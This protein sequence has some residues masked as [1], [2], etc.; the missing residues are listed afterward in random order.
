MKKKRILKRKNYYLPPELI[1]R[2]EKY[3]KKLKT[4]GSI[5]VAQLLDGLPE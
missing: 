2:G 3:A 5:V 1:K 4:S